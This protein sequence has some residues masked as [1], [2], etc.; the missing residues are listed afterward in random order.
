MGWTMARPSSTLTRASGLEPTT[1]K[2]SKRKR[3][4]YGD[5]LVARSTR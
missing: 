5:G 1:S 3:Y 2:P 4:M